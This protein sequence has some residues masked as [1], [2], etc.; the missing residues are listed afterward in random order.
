MTLATLKGM[1]FR[2]GGGQCFK[3]QSN[4]YRDGQC[5]KSFRQNGR[6]CLRFMIRCSGGVLLTQ[7]F[8]QIAVT[9]MKD[10]AEK[11]AIDLTKSTAK[12]VAKG[13][14]KS[15]VG[16]TIS[17]VYDQMSAQKQAHLA[18]GKP[19]HVSRWDQIYLV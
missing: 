19:V 6:R 3:T 9:A 8:G 13:A 14:I 4:R 18:Q 5:A 1:N 7:Q 10:V 17:G 11:T 15:A 16:T 12:S 2:E